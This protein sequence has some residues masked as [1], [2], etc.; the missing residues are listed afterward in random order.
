MS[1]NPEELETTN[2]S[3]NTISKDAER[4]A[5]IHNLLQTI[6]EVSICIQKMYT[7]KHLKE[8]APL[9]FIRRRKH[10][11]AQY[12]WRPTKTILLNSKKKR[13]FHRGT[14]VYKL[15]PDENLPS[16]LRMAWKNKQIELK[17]VN[18]KYVHENLQ[19]TVYDDKYC[20]KCV[21][22]TTRGNKLQIDPEI[23]FSLVPLDKTL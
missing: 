22:K 4:D 13:S 20:M 11:F 15:I 19:M 5:S 2:N 17:H 3:T 7:N 18:R 12:S 8:D 16:D 6:T 23:T 21:L 14:C 1:T 9:Y 10:I